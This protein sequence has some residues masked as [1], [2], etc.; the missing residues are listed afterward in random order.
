MMPCTSRCLQGVTT[1]AGRVHYM[2]T[3]RVSEEHVPV[4]GQLDDVEAQPRLRQP[5]PPG[6]H[7]APQ[8]FLQKGRSAD[9]ISPVTGS[10][11]QT[12]L[13][14]SPGGHQPP[15]QFLQ[16][17]IAVRPCCKCFPQAQGHEPPQQRFHM[18]AHKVPWKPTAHLV[19]HA[20]VSRHSR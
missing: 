6:G 12:R 17:M 5:L 13:P 4:A 16:N 10:R 14:P 11:L 3:V 2:R 7:Q 9:G 20:S 19:R 1:D 18:T 8:Q 15:Q